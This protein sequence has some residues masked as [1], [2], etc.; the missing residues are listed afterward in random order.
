MSVVFRPSQVE[1]THHRDLAVKRAS[2]W[3]GESD[4][5]APGLANLLRE[6]LSATRFPGNWLCQ[7]VV[8]YLAQIL[9][10]ATFFSVISMKSAGCRE[11]VNL[12]PGYLDNIPI[13][14]GPC[15]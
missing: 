15:Q 2:T 3:P 5:D 4:S 13:G 12:L 7:P 10:P 6:A 8:K 11:Q 1:Q 14:D 9:H